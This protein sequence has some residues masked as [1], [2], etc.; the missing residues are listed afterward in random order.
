[1]LVFFVFVEC[2]GATEE[3]TEQRATEI[4]EAGVG[5]TEQNEFGPAKKRKDQ[6]TWKANVQKKRKMEGKSYIG[7]R[8]NGE[9]VAKEPRNMGSGCEVYRNHCEENLQTTALSQQVFMDKFNQMNLAL[10]HPQK[11]ECDMSCSYKASNIPEDVWQ[12]HC[13]KKEE[14]QQGKEADK[15]T[16]KDGVKT[17]VVCMDLQALLLSPKLKASA[18]YYKTKLAVHNF[19]I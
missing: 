5:T 18:I 8:Q 3:S 1:M 10:Y 2:E 16:A 15:Q 11:D 14:T 4:E 6:S 12:T 9:E 17:M 13:L 7:K 19:T